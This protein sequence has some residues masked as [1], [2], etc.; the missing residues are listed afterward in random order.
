M[1][2]IVK[3]LWLIPALPML[4]AGLAALAPQRCRKFAAS[5]A[6]GSMVG[7]FLLSLCAFARALQIG[8]HGPKDFYNFDWLQFAAGAPGVLKLGWVL[9]PLTAVMLVMVTFVGL[10]IFIYSV[11]YMAHDENFTR[12]FTF[13]SLFAGA[14]LGVVI[15][16]SLL[17]LF[18]CWELVGLTSYLLIGFWYQKPSAAAAAKKAFITTRVGDVF[19]FLGMM[20]LYHEAGTLLFYDEGRG[21]LEQGALIGMV[22][23]TTSLGLAV[24]TCIGLLIFTGAVGKSGQVPLH[25][26]LP[27]AMEGP[28]PV[29]ALIHAATMVAAG[30]FLVARVFPLM[31]AHPEGAAAETTALQAVT[32]IGAIT[33]VFAASIAVAQ[34][35]IKRILAYS[36]VS[37]LGYMM[38]GLGTGGVAVGMFHL[39]THAFFKALLFMGAGS[40]IHGCHEEQDIRRMG[41][42]KKYMPITF[43]T[44]AVG[45]LALAGFPLF[46]SGFW[47][48]DAILHA[49]HGWPVSHVPFYLGVAGAFLTAFYMTRQVALVFFGSNRSAALPSRSAHGAKEAHDKSHAPHAG[50]HAAAEDSRAPHESPPV[51]TWP[52]IILAACAMGLSVIGTPAWP[53]FQSFLGAHHAEGFTAGV[54]KLMVISAL[55][56]FA[57]LG[58]GWWLYGRKPRRNADE[59]DVLEKLP[60]GM[61]TWFA[62]KY[63]I[64]ELYELTVIRFNAW[65]A[66]ACAFLDQWIWGGAV[67]LVSYLML[68]FSW[69]SRAFDEFVINLGFD[70]SCGGV[71]RGGR[72]MSRFQDGRVQNYLRILGV[73]LVALVLFL[74]WGG[75]K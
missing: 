62:R 11:G 34:N 52:L 51:M 46:F 16:N 3:N 56:V 22:A 37:Q 1:P 72:M 53:W 7:A 48:K 73:G 24:S 47:S 19:F 58:L 50:G 29:S 13:L 61:H 49:A 59:P 36:T 32:W 14:M 41:G 18:I 21:C 27:D 5:L 38:M 12:F 9:D 8:P 25:V 4:A 55:I 54:V 23:Q 35:D 60:L 6:I 57:G 65:S 74:I 10:L 70:Q 68:G 33:A 44:Y 30:V 67:T 43:A 64:D 17:L 71:T 42:I 63:G 66:K 28:T 69:V 40:V 31:A 39:I 15:A 2:W 20:W 45:M 26:W 75:G